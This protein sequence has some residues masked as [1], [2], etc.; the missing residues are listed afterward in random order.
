[1]SHYCYL[2]KFY[3]KVCTLEEKSKSFYA[4]IELHYLNRAFPESDPRWTK[5]KAKREL[6]KKRV[7]MMVYFPDDEVKKGLI[8]RAKEAD[9]SP[10]AYIR[11]MC[12][13]DKK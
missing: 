1:M 6:K 12:L 11:K 4:T 8:K 10:S 2:L 9:L 7:Y 3:I 5:K 13:G